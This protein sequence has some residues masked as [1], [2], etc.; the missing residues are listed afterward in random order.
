M[1]SIRPLFRAIPV[2]D[3]ILL[4]YFFCVIL[5]WYFRNCGTVSFLLLC[6]CR[7]AAGRQYARDFVALSWCRNKCIRVI[8]LRPPG[9]VVPGWLL[10]YCGCFFFVCSF[11]AVCRSISPRCLGRLPWDFE[12]WLQMCAKYGGTSPKNG[13]NCFFTIRR[14]ISELPRPIAGK[15]CHMIGNRWSVKS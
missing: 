6:P 13:G 10:F 4:L 1:S 12:T 5:L 3:S 14:E 15:L 7:I 2:R 8:W 11:L 9:T